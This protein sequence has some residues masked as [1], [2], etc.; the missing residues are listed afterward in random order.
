[1]N[2]DDQLQR[3]NIRVKP[4]L[5]ER[6]NILNQRAKETQSLKQQLDEK[7]RDT[8]LRTP[9]DISSHQGKINNDT[10]DIGRPVFPNGETPRQTKNDVPDISKLQI[11]SSSPLSDNVES[12][13]KSVSRNILQEQESPIEAPRQNKS[14]G[15]TQKSSADYKKV[16]ESLAFQTNKSFLSKDMF[17]QVVV[18]LNLG[19]GEYWTQKVESEAAFA[20]MMRDLGEEQGSIPPEK[21]PKL[22]PVIGDL[23]ACQFFNIWH[24]ASIVSLDP[25]TV[26]YIDYGNDEVLTQNDIRPLGTFAEIPRYARKIRVLNAKGTKYEHLGEN[27]KFSVKLISED[28]DGVLSVVT[29]DLEG[30]SPFQPFKSS[31]QNGSSSSPKGPSPPD[32][33][34]PP[35]SP[36]DS[37]KGQQGPKSNEAIK[38]DSPTPTG[39]VIDNLEIKDLGVMEIHTL[40]RKNAYSVTIVP[41]KFYEYYKKV[42]ME[43]PAKCITKAKTTDNY[44]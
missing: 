34:E 9:N 6:V 3:S 17:T 18:V 20:K 32:R 25:L 36:R 39:S 13:E 5:K 16:E 7:E 21:A 2:G 12:K 1:M 27:E 10:N 4:E 33:T 31:S 37:S 30:D 8:S 38:K 35:T 22:K 14:P 11:S 23:V 43:L 24:R 44:Q 29:P 26:H 15:L 42:L 41:N 40:L 19:K 28:A